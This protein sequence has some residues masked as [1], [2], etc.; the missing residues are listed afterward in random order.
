MSAAEDKS[1]VK[2]REPVGG[3]DRRDPES[4]GR[5]EAPG[6]PECVPVG[7]EEV[8]IEEELWALCQLGQKE[9]ELTGLGTW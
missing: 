5:S 1:S 8:V 2:S 4:P 6:S 9:M 3:S 7:K